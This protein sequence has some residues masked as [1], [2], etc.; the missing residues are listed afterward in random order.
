[1]SG[2]W[3]LVAAVSNF[4]IPG[5]EVSF[6]EAGPGSLLPGTTSGREPLTSDGG[7]RINK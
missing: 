6:P 7:E 1:M 2:W 4:L 3:T 5:S